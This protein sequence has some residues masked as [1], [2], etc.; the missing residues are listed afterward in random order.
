MREDE[1]RKLM[2]PQMIEK[3]LRVRKVVGGSTWVTDVNSLLQKVRYKK[4]VLT[5]RDMRFLNNLYSVFTRE[6]E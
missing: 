2:K 4:Y 6:M 3:I 5:K 1:G